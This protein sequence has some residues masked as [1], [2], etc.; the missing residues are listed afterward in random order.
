VSVLTVD[1]E[2]VKNLC[3][4]L[5]DFLLSQEVEERVTPELILKFCT[6]ENTR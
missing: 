3:L 4:T 5:T 1:H 6:S 2:A